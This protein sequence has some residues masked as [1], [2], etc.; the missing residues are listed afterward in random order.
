METSKTINTNISMGNDLITLPLKNFTAS[1]MD[2]FFAICYKCQRQGSN[3]LRIPIAELRQ[4]ARYK[5]VSNK[6]L[7]DAIEST[8]KKITTMIVLFFLPDLELTT[9]MTLLKS[10]VKLYIHCWINIKDCGTY[11]FDK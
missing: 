7:M 2:L 11:L 5:N 10:L 6:E 9:K 3:E 8:G 4:L 1:E